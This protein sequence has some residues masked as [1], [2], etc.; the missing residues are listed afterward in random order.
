MCTAMYRMSIVLTPTGL[1]M[2]WLLVHTLAVS[3]LHTIET[4]QYLA[5]CAIVI[6]CICLQGHCNQLVCIIIS[7]CA[8]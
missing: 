2:Q 4:A 6:M 1:S 3:K 8:L 5:A 7:W